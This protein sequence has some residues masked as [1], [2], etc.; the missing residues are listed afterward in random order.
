MTDPRFLLFLLAL[1]FLGS[2]AAAWLPTHGRTRAAVLAGAISLTGALLV[3]SAFPAMMAGE[4]MR[5]ELAWLP[6]LGLNLVVRMDGFSWFFSLMVLG[7][8]SLVILYARY[9]MSPS[10]PVPR[11]FSFLMAFMGS[12][13]GVVLS[14][15]LIQSSSS[16]N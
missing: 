7:I 10:D 11:F 8:G 9:Y 12:M 14:G 2:L 3:L 13:M 5:Y 1:P 4:V 16:G 15:N 6:S